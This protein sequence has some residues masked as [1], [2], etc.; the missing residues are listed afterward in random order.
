M[1]H[2]TNKFIIP[3][4]SLH[5]MNIPGTRYEGPLERKTNR[6]NTVMCYIMAVV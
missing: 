1:F 6:V 2:F 3:L 4:E 5:A